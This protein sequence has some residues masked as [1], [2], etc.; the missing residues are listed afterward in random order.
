MKMSVQISL[1]LVCFNAFAGLVVATGVAGDLGI[2]VQEGYE[3][4]E[5]ATVE[6]PDLGGSGIQSTLFAMYNRLTQ[7]VADIMWAI[8]PG[9]QMLKAYVPDAWVDFVLLPVSSVIVGKDMIAFARGTD[10]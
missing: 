8:T 1:F 2:H 9:Y 3:V 4:V 6:E 10:L 7:Q 5:P